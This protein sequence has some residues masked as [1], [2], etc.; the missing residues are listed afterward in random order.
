MKKLYICQ[1]VDSVSETVVSTFTAPTP[2]YFDRQMEA[3]FNDCK[4]KS[5]PVADFEGFIVAAVE[6]CET[7]DDATSLL[8]EGELYVYHGATYLDSACNE[9]GQEKE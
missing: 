9:T 4:K 8:E 5:I 7:F 1:V 3:F 6:V 2:K